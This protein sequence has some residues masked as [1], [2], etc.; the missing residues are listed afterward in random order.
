[1]WYLEHFSSVGIDPDPHARKSSFCDIYRNGDIVPDITSYVMHHFDSS[2]MLKHVVLPDQL[3]IT[4]LYGKQG[5]TWLDIQAETRHN[6][7]IE[8][9]AH[10]IFMLTDR[11]LTYITD[12]FHLLLTDF[13]D[14]GMHAHNDIPSRFM[15]LRHPPKRA[16][17]YATSST[18]INSLPKINLHHVHV[19]YWLFYNSSLSHSRYSDNMQHYLD[20]IAQSTYPKQLIF[21]NLKPR[22]Y[23]LKS[24][25]YMFQQGTL[26]DPAL[27]WSLADKVY[28]ITGRGI[29]EDL[30]TKLVKQDQFS[31]QIV[32]N[33][34]DSEK[35]LY[36]QFID[37][38]ELPKLYSPVDNLVQI[39][40]SN[41]DDF[42]VFNW[43]YC[44]ETYYGG[45]L[46][47]RFGLGTS[48]FL[49]EKTYKSF[50]QASMPLTLCEGDTY[51]Y[52]TNLGFRVDN[53]QLDCYTG[54]EERFINVMRLID[55]ILEHG[56]VPN[57]DNILHNFEL[58]TDIKH[59]AHIYN[60]CLINIVDTLTI[61]NQDL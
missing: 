57:R 10:W 48:S 31:Q 49:T 22:L 43:S 29:G 17:I 39:L 47:L 13:E 3:R 54:S 19:P 55:D 52:L 38:Y 14:G 34:T 37:T 8:M 56:I 27:E 26:D 6:I 24:L 60:Q 21:L 33:L 1:M 20:T 51:N 23:R 61:H 36:T 4:E 2:E 15:T 46:P 35:Q 50:M 5:I 12:R 44:V 42:A 28:T 32:G 18:H 40:N 58:I 59:T 30:Q 11:Q 25:L 41:P 16:V 53:Q 9:P 7:V 45:E